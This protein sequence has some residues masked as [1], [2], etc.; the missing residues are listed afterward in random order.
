[1]IRLTRWIRLA[2]MLALL[3]DSARGD[4]LP[5]RTHCLN[6]ESEFCASA[7]IDIN[8]DG[9]LDVV[10]GGYWYAAPD[11]KR[12]VLRD[13]EVIGGRYDDYSNLPL[14][15]NGDGWTDLVSAN[16]RSRK[17]FWIEHPGPALGAWKVHTIAEP[18]PM[19]T[20][21]LFDIDGDGRLDV[22]PNGAQF[23]AWWELAPAQPGDGPAPIRWL[24][25]EL[26][27]EAAGHGIGFGDIDGDGR[28]DVVGPQGWFGG[29]ANP[30]RDRW[31]PHPEFV[32]HRDA[33]VPILVFDVDGD[34][35]ADVV[36]S[37]AHHTGLY[38]LE[39]KPGPSGER[40]WTMH[41][42]DSS[43]SQAHA[44]LLGDLDN[45]SQ[46][47]VVA[48]KRYLAH[49]GRD[50]GEYDPLQVCAYT[51][52]R[53]TRT[54]NRRM[55][56]RGGKVGFGLDPKLVDI[57]GDGDLDLI[58][59]GR[60]GLHLLENL[61]VVNADD[62][63]KPPQPPLPPDYPD[64]ANLLMYKDEQN[65][66]QPV[67]TRA[68]WA[69]RR[70]HL[71]AHLQRVMG[72]LPEPSQRVP[73]DVVVQDEARAPAYLRRRITY[74][75][76]PGDRVPAWLLLPEKLDRRAPAMLCLHQTT[77]IGKDEPAGL[78]GLANLHYAHELAERGYVCLVPDYP[79]FGEY[80]FDFQQARDRYASGSMKAIWNNLRGV[81]L[82]ESLPEVDPDRI[83]VIGHSLGGHNALFTATFDQRIA[84]VV[85]SCG[86]TAFHDYYQGN[87]QGWTSDR[88]MPRIRDQF[89]N[90][91]NQVPFDF[92]EIVAALAPRAF[93]T[94]SPV[95][96]AN[97]DVAGVRKIEARTQQVYEMAGS[98]EQM[99]FVYPDCG[100]DF[101]EAVRKQA[102]DWLDE[103]LK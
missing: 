79:S 38:W 84:A 86:F 5:F 2:L 28:G 57:D 55:I 49:E 60:S 85:T 88:Y 47:E 36:W 19:E 82:L 35:D 73:L 31:M 72:V 65:R 48:G 91:P 94:N 51:Y 97:F 75:A 39:Q 99:Q 92:Y 56:S 87:L 53:T 37:R 50:L 15:V 26:P 17:L 64:H 27:E 1:M 102:Y 100:H 52:H 58:G 59:P 8:H 70:S 41:V 93:F 30:R 63:Y 34:R 83:G 69:I 6:A 103:K 22:L 24:R 42:I 67:R 7:A 98:R 76:E 29:P 78:G 23:A 3:A 45:D 54:W 89:H 80:R 66:D 12:H 9:R 32:L 68:E 71:L 95:G 43:W 21:R 74:A 40:R 33:C 90:D 13:V 81:D 4:D 101:P 77:A 96:D 25:H 14:D 20:A 11:W 62:G 10:C 18:G 16:Y 61:A 46:P 44:L